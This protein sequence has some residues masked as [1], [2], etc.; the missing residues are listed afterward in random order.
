MG[1]RVVVAECM[2]GNEN[3]RLNKRK[4]INEALHNTDW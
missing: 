1:A 2:L 3:Y 4:T